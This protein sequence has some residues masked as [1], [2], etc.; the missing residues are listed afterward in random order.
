MFPSGSDWIIGIKTNSLNADASDVT[1]MLRINA[2]ASD[3]AVPQKTP[4]CQEE[5]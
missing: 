4:A 1:R 5:P 3:L 2:D